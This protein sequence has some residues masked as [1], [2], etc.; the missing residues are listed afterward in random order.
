MQPWIVKK[1]TDYI[2]E[3]EKSLVDFFL[4]KLKGHSNPTDILNDL[5]DVMEDDAELFMKQLWRKLIFES[6]RC[7]VTL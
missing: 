6:L 4:T 3:E 2:G 7:T 1:V 5:Q